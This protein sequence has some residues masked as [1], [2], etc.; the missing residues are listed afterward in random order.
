MGTESLAFLSP[1]LLPEETHCIGNEVNIYKLYFTKG[2]MNMGE[3]L[4][5]TNELSAMLGV[6]VNTLQIWRHQGKGPKYFKLS[7]RAVRYKERDILAWM[8]NSMIETEA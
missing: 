1:F 8:D 5:N 4:L 2:G 3:K 6:T 7:R